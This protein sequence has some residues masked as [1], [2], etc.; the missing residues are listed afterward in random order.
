MAESNRASLPNPNEQPLECSV[1]RAIDELFSCVSLGHQAMHYYRY[2]RRKDCQVKRENLKFCLKVNLKP[3]AEKQRLLGERE[4]TK[5]TTLASQPNCLDV[6]TLRTEP[7]PNF[8]FSNPATVAPDDS[9]QPPANSATG[10]PTSDREQSS[11]EAE[12]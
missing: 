10:S 2:G 11:I 3:E 9:T 12:Q 6:W 8:P 5:E 1:R 4:Q 7:L